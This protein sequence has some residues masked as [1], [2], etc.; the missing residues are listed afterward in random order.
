MFRLGRFA[1]KVY[2][3][4]E[5][6]RIQECCMVISDK[7]AECESWLKKQHEKDFVRC[8]KCYGCTCAKQTFKQ[9]LKKG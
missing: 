8:K 2:T 7:Q 5:A 3:E 1:G 4:Q 6:L 9:E